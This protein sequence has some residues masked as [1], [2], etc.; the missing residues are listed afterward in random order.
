MATKIQQL[1]ET[2]RR[3]FA[4]QK[5]AG[6]QTEDINANE[7]KAEN[8]AETEVTAEK[9][10]LREMKEIVKQMGA[11]QRMLKEHR[12]TVNFK[13]ER[14]TVEFVTSKSEYKNGKYV[15]TDQNVKIYLTPKN[16]SQLLTGAYFQPEGINAALW[17]IPEDKASD[18]Q[19][20]YYVGLIPVP[21]LSKTE[22][23]IMKFG[24]TTGMVANFNDAYALLRYERKTKK[25]DYLEKLREEVNNGCHP[26]IKR[27]MDYFRDDAEKEG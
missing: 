13:G 12:K 9:H 26:G 3:F 10:G 14:Q 2:V 8:I 6:M 24:S 23:D 25:N 19:F 11:M 4:G 1:K 18:D 21:S 16:A 22:G 20:V 7:I 5:A 27:I 17:R 15:Y